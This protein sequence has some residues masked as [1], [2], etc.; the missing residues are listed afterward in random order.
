MTQTLA[1]LDLGSNSIRTTITE[2]DNEGNFQV[3]ERLQ[4]MVRISKG[5]GKE[6]TIKPEALDRAMKALASF[7]EVYDKYKNLKIIAVATAAV[8]QAA[9]QKEFLEQFKKVM[10]FSLK[11]ISGYEE[12]EYDFYGVIGT[13]PVNDGV[14]I[15]TGGASTEIILVQK[16][17]L[18]ERVSIPLGA[19]NISESFLDGDPITSASLFR[20]SVE[21][22]SILNNLPWLK[23]AVNYPI[24]AIGGSNRTL[25]KIRKNE[26]NQTELPIHGYHMN[27]QNVDDIIYELLNKTNEE[28]QNI[29]GLA[30]ERSQIIIG[31]LLPIRLIMEKIDCEQIIFSQ[32]GA[33]EGIL[34]KEIETQTKKS[35]QTT[36]I[37]NMTI[38]EI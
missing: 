36:D 12:A 31:G 29:K 6:K 5:M 38:D 34:F 33:R 16:G 24:I 18:K 20:A 19:V 35:I 17:A 3:F 4:E 2:Y 15:D 8:R 28:R 27:R 26:L 7:K 25:A 32:S 14:I 1:I 13:L 30:K 37:S 9:N 10:G 11:V 21:L 22:S 23:E